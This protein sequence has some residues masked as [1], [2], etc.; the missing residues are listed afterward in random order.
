MIIYEFESKVYISLKVN[1]ECY[2]CCVRYACEWWMVCND[3]R[4]I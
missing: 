2:A 1:N 3:D 4:D